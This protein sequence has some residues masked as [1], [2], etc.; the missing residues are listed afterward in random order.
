MDEMYRNIAIALVV[1]ITGIYCSYI[2][3]PYIAKGLEVVS[4]EIIK[5][6]LPE[7]K[8]TTKFIFVLSS[9]IILKIM[10]TSIIGADIST[11]SIPIIETLPVVNQVIE[12]IVKY[13]DYSEAIKNDLIFLSELKPVTTFLNNTNSLNIILHCLNMKMANSCFFIE[14]RMF[15]HYDTIYIKQLDYLARIENAEI[16]KNAPILREYFLS[17]QLNLNIDYADLMQQCNAVNHDSMI[18]FLLEV[19]YRYGSGVGGVSLHEL[20]LR[21]A[22]AFNY[23]NLHSNFFAATIS[24]DMD[25]VFDLKKAFYIQSFMD[26]S[27]EPYLSFGKFDIYDM[28]VV[29]GTNVND[30]INNSII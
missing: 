25:Y 1:G 4:E 28:A 5:L 26:G 6:P 16:V 19:T 2:I 18:L 14:A 12:D 23:C 17:K 20:M 30:I 9:L 11:I 27:I 8:E 22:V 7:E 24:L 15:D 13:S 21:N 29:Q 3:S 10:I